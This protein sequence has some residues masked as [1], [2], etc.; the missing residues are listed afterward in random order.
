[1]HKICH[2]VDFNMQ[3]M[4]NTCA[5]YADICIKNTKCVQKYAQNMQ[6]ICCY[7]Q[8]YAQNLHYLDINMRNM[9][10]MR[11]IICRNMQKM[12]A[13]NTHKICRICI[14][15]CNIHLRALST[16]LML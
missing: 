2:Y 5:K 3:N 6:Q 11:K 8:K 12:Y 1:M 14:S 16:L 15:L 13:E 4:Q 7:T 9:L 10:N